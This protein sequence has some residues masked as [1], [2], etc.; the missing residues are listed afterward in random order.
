ME[1]PITRLGYIVR[2][3]SSSEVAEAIFN[4]TPTNV[5]HAALALYS[6]GGVLRAVHLHTPAYSR[7]RDIDVTGTQDNRCSIHVITSRR[8][9]RAPWNA[10]HT[11]TLVQLIVRL[12]C[13]VNEERCGVGR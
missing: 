8:L 12:D 11:A 6:D 10:Q 1:N 13:C 3:R 4:E 5:Q 9:L 2:D 7:V